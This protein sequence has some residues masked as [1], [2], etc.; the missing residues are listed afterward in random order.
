MK[1]KLAAIL[2][3]VFFVIAQMTPVHAAE[4]NAVDIN[5]QPDL[6]I[7]EINLTNT[8]FQ[9]GDEVTFEVV[10]TN[11]GAAMKENNWVGLSIAV[12][13]NT[14]ENMTVAGVIGSGQ[15]V[16]YT[17]RAY[18]AQSSSFAVEVV[19]DSTNVVTESDENNN[20]FS[21]R[22]KS[23]P[24]IPD[25][26]I[27]NVDVDHADFAGNEA[28][29][30]VTVKNKGAA[31]AEYGLV[32][33]QLD[34]NGELHMLAESAYMG[35]LQE[36]VL[37]TEPIATLDDR[38]EVKAVV[39]PDNLV[40]E[41]VED[42]NEYTRIIQSFQTEK[43]IW[44]SVRIG[45]G[46]YCT[47]MVQHPKDPSIVYARTD[48]GGLYK[49]DGNT[50]SWTQ[51]L[52]K[53]SA[54]NQ[55]FTGVNAVA[56][57][58]NNTNV[59]YAACGLYSKRKLKSWSSPI[60]PNDV[61]KSKDGGKTWERTNLNIDF[62]ANGD[63]RSAGESIAVDPNNSDIVYVGGHFD[64]LWRTNNATHKTITWEK[65]PTNYIP[66]DIN[67]EYL[68]QGVRG[69]RVVAFDPREVKD[70]KT[71]IIYA[72]V[73][74]H[75]VYQST[76]AGDTWHLM[77]GSPERPH[78][79]RVLPNGDLVVGGSTELYK[80]VDGKFE[81]ISP[82]NN[83]YYTAVAVS[84]ANPDIIITA[85]SSGGYMNP[86]YYTENGGL[87]WI[88]KGSKMVFDTEV[89]WWFQNRQRASIS[90]FFFNIEN[91]NEVWFSEW[92][93]IFM[94][95]D[96][97]ADEPIVK[98]Y[99][100]GYEL[101]CNLGIITP[102]SGARLLQTAADI[103]GTRHLDLAEFPSK[104]FD[105][106]AATDGCDI[107]F[108]EEDPNVV[109][110]I[111]SMMHAEQGGWGGYSLDN[112]L[113]W[114]AFES[115]PAPEGG[116]NNEE[117]NTWGDGYAN[118][119]LAVGSRKIYNGN[120]AI[121]T[122]PLGAN[123][124]VS[125]DMGTTWTTV[126]GLPQNRV[127]SMWEAYRPLCADSVNGAR[128]YCFD[129]GVV[130]VSEDGGYNF[131]PK[132]SVPTATLYNIKPLPYR[133]GD[134]WVSSQTQG[135]WRSTDAGTTFNRIERIDNCI[136]F[137][138]GKEYGEGYPPT[139][140]VYGVIDGVRGYFKSHDL[141][142]TFILINPDGFEVYGPNFM[143]ADRQTYGIV[144]LSTNGFGVI[145]GST[146]E[147][148][149]VKPRVILPVERVVTNVQDYTLE[150]YTQ[151]NRKD[152]GNTITV[153]YS[154]NDGP[155]QVV[156]GLQGKTTL[157]LSLQ[158]G[159]NVLKAKAIDVNGNISKEQQVEIEYVEGALMSHVAVPFAM[160][161]ENQTEVTGKIFPDS[162][163]LEIT[164]N[165]VQ[166]T[167]N[168]GDLAF[169]ATIPLADG[170]NAIEVVAK[171]A[172]GTVDTAQLSIVSDTVAPTLEFANFNEN[173]DTNLV[174]MEGIMSEQATVEVNGILYR[175]D[176]ANHVRIPAGLKEGFNTLTFN[177]TDPAGNKSQVV[178]SITYNRQSSGALLAGVADATKSTPDID[179]TLSENEDWVMDYLISKPVNGATE[180]T[181]AFGV[182]YDDQYLYVGAHVLDFELVAGSESEVYN[183]DG[184]E[185][186]LDGDNAK[187]ELFD[188]NDKQI[189]VDIEGRAFTSS[190][191]ANDIVR[192]IYKNDTG[193]TMEI[194]IPWSMVGNAG[195]TAIGFDVAFNDSDKAG[196][197]DGSSMWFGTSN[198]WQSAAAFGTLNLK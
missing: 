117:W 180:A 100:D 113:T 119:K 1:R 81:I 55:S 88:E 115:Y 76:D 169:A 57:D 106:P 6:V 93:G 125:H 67:G 188:D 168:P 123:A 163:G 104:V 33:V 52:F 192:K 56:V 198:N 150:M 183:N 89:G 7:S 23:L 54:Q 16:T 145:Y 4:S 60:T 98:N 182:K 84:P 185:I 178:K 108:C 43:Y 42:N 158:P 83:R 51:L 28:R 151:D 140:Y 48:V 176:D 18:I 154:L 26:V 36:I 167:I 75:G 27:T 20:G 128:F 101:I 69:V 187:A 72:G 156:E 130:Y 136:N 64:G 11:Q 179:G 197:R 5:A 17:S 35:A 105:N 8:A 78:V 70:G 135:L 22:I 120:P 40:P 96:I 160:T 147:N 134:V 148:D 142:E 184:I 111:T 61:L 66:D 25:Y 10:V 30:S 12:D 29:L 133:E 110:R 38:L 124:A 131:E 92:S 107:Q 193:Y 91:P 62:E 138:F 65:I 45:G 90:D 102:P 41:Q 122:Y 195:K 31:D 15:S 112:G 175:T 94:I 73:F 71:Q 181:A 162:V 87:S 19:C 116:N 53:E 39:D 47:G 165:G 24:A 13:N 114:T 14:A 196:Q 144:Y 49:W 2:T 9:R 174:V 170:E 171:D 166:A 3:A 74:G 137:A 173:S 50:R 103:D 157:P 68:Y 161:K 46:G 141:G 118:G 44:D 126:K 172:A 194:A 127:N 190:G 189:V 21:G 109:V 95:Q 153:R 99:I 132:G 63:A 97:T 129:G 121:V 146:Y 80:C 79:I 86:I 82:V 186:Y 149:V 139:L 85:N 177:L 164:V 159:V 77:E 143:E 32:N 37:E 191:D 152:E 59:V 58:P 34:I 155:E